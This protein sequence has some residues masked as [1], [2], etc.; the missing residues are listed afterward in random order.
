MGR[1]YREKNKWVSF[2]SKELNMDNSKIEEFNLNPNFN[3]S[4]FSINLSNK[5]FLKI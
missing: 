2:T 3:K 5:V 4:K 1:S